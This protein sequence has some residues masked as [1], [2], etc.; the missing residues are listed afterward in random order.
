[1]FKDG[2]VMGSLSDIFE[3]NLRC[4][5]LFGWEFVPSIMNV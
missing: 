2:S 5:V 3:L 4:V 1:M